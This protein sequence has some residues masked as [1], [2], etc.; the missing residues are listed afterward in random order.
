MSEVTKYKRST[1]LKYKPNGK[2]VWVMY[3]SLSAGGLNYD[4]ANVYVMQKGGDLITIPIALQNE[5]LE[6]YPPSER[7]ENDDGGEAV[8]L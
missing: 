5:F 8:V 6:P 7:D 2:A 1:R 3:N 4:T